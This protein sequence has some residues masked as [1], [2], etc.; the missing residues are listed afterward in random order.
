[1]TVSVAVEAL[2]PGRICVVVTAPSM[3]TCGVP[4]IVTITITRRIGSGEAPP[5]S[6]N[7]VCKRRLRI[8]RERQLENRCG[9]RRWW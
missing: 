3:I 4:M 5:A 1:M 6:T 8:D 7:S 2:V 9:R